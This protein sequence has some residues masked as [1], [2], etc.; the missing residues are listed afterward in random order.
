MKTRPP[1]VLVIDDEIGAPRSSWH[2]GFIEAYGQPWLEF[3]FSDARDKDGEFS[4]VAALEFVRKNLDASLVLLDIIFGSR[5][6][7]GLQILETIRAVY[8]YIPVIMLTSVSDP[9]VRDRC[10]RLAETYLVKDTFTPAQLEAEVQKYAIPARDRIIGDSKAMDEVRRTIAGYAEAPN[11]PVLVHGETGTGKELAARSLHRLSARA[12]G[13]LLALNCAQITDSLEGSEL[14]GHARGAFTG[15]D[16]HHVGL[17]ESAN[18]GTLF[19]DEIGTMRLPLQ[20]KLLRVIEDGNVRRV[21]E[22]RDRLVD[23]RLVGATTA[24]LKGMA[25][26][27]EFT[28]A[29]YYRLRGGEIY[30]PPLRERSDDIPELVDYW[31]GFLHHRDFQADPP[32]SITPEALECL[33]SYKWPGNVRELVQTLGNAIVKCY[34]IA[35]ARAIEPEHLPRELFSNG[36]GS[37]PRGKARVDQIL[38]ED[39]TQWA[40]VRTLREIELLREAWTL[41]GGNSRRTMKALFPNV[42]APSETYLRRYV[43]GLIVGTWGNQG[44]LASER[45]RAALGPL[46]EAYLKERETSAWNKIKTI[47]FRMV[48]RNRNVLTGAGVPVET[49]ENAWSMSDWRTIA[50]AAAESEQELKIRSGTERN[51]VRFVKD[52]R[53]LSQLC[54]KMAAWQDEEAAP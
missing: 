23:V 43:H 32:F 11:L 37:A 3:V 45:H 40:D 39:E 29:L 12:S 48:V 24:D 52:F 50:D 51:L 35:K 1:K 6:S 7:F 47:V 38:P 27:G 25:A 19:L 21:G 10:L 18:G 22:T 15:A 49:I 34:K 26:R 4:Q 2:R 31:L 46:Y 54:S 30:V 13:P 33:R 9:E 42:G 20:E 16:R 5:E 28:Q 8:P 17:I 53:T 41:S 14:F 36:T 44:V